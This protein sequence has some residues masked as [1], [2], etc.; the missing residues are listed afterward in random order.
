VLASRELGPGF[1]PQHGMRAG[2]GGWCSLLLLRSQMS[3]LCN[4]FPASNWTT[5]WA[6]VL[7]L[8][9]IKLSLCF[10]NVR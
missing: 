9:L 3:K 8:I 4:G 1:D 7:I 2:T 6:E 10:D 5:V